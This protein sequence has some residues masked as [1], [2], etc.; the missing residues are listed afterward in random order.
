MSEGILRWAVG[1]WTV[2]CKLAQ[3]EK[4]EILVNQALAGSSG[5]S[6]VPVGIVW[7][8]DPLETRQRGVTEIDAAR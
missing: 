8:A 1:K 2:T 7:L 4:C 6:A 5:A 3:N